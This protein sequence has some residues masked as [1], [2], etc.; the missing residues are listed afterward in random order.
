[1]N[2]PSKILENAVDQIASL[3]GIGK[4]T[5][6]RLALSLLKRNQHE[7]S[8]FV[9]SIDELKKSIK[10]CDT[11]F[12]LS[13]DPTCK[14]CSNPLRDHGILCVVEDIR[15]VMAIESTNQFKGVY[16]VLGGIISPMDGIGPSDL[17][18]NE[19]LARLKGDVKEIILA[20]ST[21][22]EGDTTA[23]YLY[24][25][26]QDSDVAISTIARGVS[27]G[28]ELEFIDEV[29]LGRSILQRMPYKNTLHKEM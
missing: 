17:R 19:L 12:N 25:K 16:H 23:F 10:H 6:L 8:D 2:I 5:A 14:V 27:I 11:C 13:D 9:T 3:P 28:D 20:L 22:M 26:L 15:D 21:T 24:R 18:I 1:M 7:V 4:K 29:T